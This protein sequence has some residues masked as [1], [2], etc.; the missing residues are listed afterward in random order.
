MQVFHPWRVRLDIQLRCWVGSIW[1]KG[2]HPALSFARSVGQ[3][4]GREFTAVH[5]NMCG[6]SNQLINPTE[7]RERL[8]TRGACCG[9]LELG[10]NLCRLLAC[11]SHLVALQRRLAYHL[12]STYCLCLSPAQVVG[13]HED[14][15]FSKTY[16]QKKR[17]CSFHM[18]ADSVQLQM[19]DPTLWR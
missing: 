12:S 15:T 4:M 13:C 8:M 7:A 18:Q 14:L 6:G 11:L 9:H 3:D 17:T 2:S 5:L 16:C 10:C 19:G 1:R